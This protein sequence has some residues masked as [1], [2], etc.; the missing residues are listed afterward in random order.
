MEEIRRGVRQTA[1][2]SILLD[3]D[4]PSDKCRQKAQ[5]QKDEGLKEQ[6]LADLGPQHES[7]NTKYHKSNTFPGVIDAG[8]SHS[9]LLLTGSDNT[10]EAFE[11]PECEIS[12][13]MK[14]GDIKDA[15]KGVRS[16]AVEMIERCERLLNAKAPERIFQI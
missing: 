7:P 15:W 16:R 11:L 2:E 1:P 5:D 3:S 14:G 6:S 10:E 4:L 9:E 13:L 12:E 8:K